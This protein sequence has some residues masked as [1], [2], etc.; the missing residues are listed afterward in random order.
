MK[1]LP[2]EMALRNLKRRGA[3]EVESVGQQWGVEL[4]FGSLWRWR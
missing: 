3:P 4:T 1:L 2:Q